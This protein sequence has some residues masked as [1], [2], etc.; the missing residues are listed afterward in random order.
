MR[1]ESAALTFEVEETPRQEFGTGLRARL[2][3]SAMD[4]GISFQDLLNRIDRHDR[5][6][7]ASRR[8]TTTDTGA[9][10]VVQSPGNAQ[11]TTEP[12]AA[13]LQSG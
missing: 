6:S 1:Q 11:I 8:A 12:G 7:E 3:R 4:F 9:A 2:E 13:A 10:T 5:R